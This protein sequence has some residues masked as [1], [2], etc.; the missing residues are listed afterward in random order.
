VVDALP[1]GAEAAMSEPLNVPRLEYVSRGPYMATM[2]WHLID[3]VAWLWQPGLAECLF[4]M[5][6]PDQAPGSPGAPDR[7]V[8]FDA[9]GVTVFGFLS[10]PTVPICHVITSEV[11]DIMRSVGLDEDLNV[12]DLELEMM[13]R[14]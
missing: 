2:E 11:A 14:R 12:T 13:S 1:L 7:R 4:W 9:R 6:D 10:D 8:V 3:Q 5:L